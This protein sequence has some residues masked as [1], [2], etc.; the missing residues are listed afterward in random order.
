MRLILGVDM[1]R[2]T[3]IITSIVILILAAGCGPG[4]T[5]NPTLTPLPTTT[6]TSTSAP[7]STAT[8]TPISVTDTPAPPGKI[9]G[10]VVDSSG[11]PLAGVGIKLLEDHDLV[12]ETKSDSEGRFTFENIPRENM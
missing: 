7:T 1:K 8:I 5:I 3:L 6:S 2:R 4:A 12:R 10:V 11:A 9:S